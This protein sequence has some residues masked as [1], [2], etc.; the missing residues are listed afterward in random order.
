MPANVSQHYVSRVYLKQ[1]SP[2]AK[3]ELWRFDGQEIVHKS[4]VSQCAE[5]YFYSSSDPKFFQIMEDTYGT[6]LDK[7]I[8]RGKTLTAKNRLGL[9]LMMFD[10]HCRNPAYTNLTG[11]KNVDS[12][13]ALIHCLHILLGESGTPLSSEQLF[14]HLRNTWRVRLLETS[15]EPGLITSDN[16]ALW[17]TFDETEDRKRLHFMLL[18]I[19]PRC[20][21]VAW[22]MRFVRVNGCGLTRDD[23]TGISFGQIQHCTRFVYCSSKPSL[24]ELPEA[25]LRWKERERPEGQVRTN[26]CDFNFLRCLKN[27]TGFSFLTS[28]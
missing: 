11:K 12:Y 22:D 16:P 23:Q 28:I 5:D 1:F 17:F 15:C 2:T 4:V 10:L 14:Q 13:N 7:R 24:D 9:I 3:N 8:K 27:D 26:S 19:T 21:A 20:C 18:P 25:R 6:I